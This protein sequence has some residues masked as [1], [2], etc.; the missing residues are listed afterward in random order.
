[1]N[2]NSEVPA[3]CEEEEKPTLGLPEDV[4]N[5]KLGLPQNVLI[6]ETFGSNGCKGIQ[7]L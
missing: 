1:M 7:R 6:V 4:A 5:M 2:G 3:T